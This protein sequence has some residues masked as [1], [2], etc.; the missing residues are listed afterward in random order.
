MKYK[1]KCE[2]KLLL[3]AG[4]VM[5]ARSRATCAYKLAKRLATAETRDLLV[6][7]GCYRDFYCTNKISLL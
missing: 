1:N 3:S 7:F 5:H 2:A 6:H 4:E